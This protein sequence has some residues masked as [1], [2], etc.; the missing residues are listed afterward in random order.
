[1]ILLDDMNDFYNVSWK[2]QNVK[3]LLELGSRVEFFKGDICNDTFVDS[4]F[5]KT[6]PTILAHLAARAGVR[7]SIRNPIAYV[8][9]NLEGTTRI[10]EA[11]RRY[12]VRNLVLASSSSVYGGSKSTY[13]SEDETVDRP[14]SPYA[15]TKKATELMAHAYHHLYGLNITM[16]RF[17][18]V[19]GPRGRPDMAPFQFLDKIS[20]GIPITQFGDGTSQRDYTYVD[21]IVNGIVRAIDRPYGFEIMNLGKGSGTSLKEFIALIERYTKKKANIQR[22]PPQPGD[23]PYTRANVDKAKKLLGYKAQVPV[24]EGIQRMVKWYQETF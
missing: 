14:I 21:D 9:S 2:E 23:V 3:R 22:L 5:A 4:V 16:L 1:V 15:A 6:Y 10:L 12:N 7:P 8:Q 18:T 13:F 17:F 11:S 24:N 19:Y 20:R